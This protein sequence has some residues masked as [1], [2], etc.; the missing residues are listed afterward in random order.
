M[1]RQDPEDNNDHQKRN[2]V[3]YHQAVLDLGPYLRAP[4]VDNIDNKN[5]SIYKKGSLPILRAVVGIIDDQER[6]NDSTSEER[7]RGIASLP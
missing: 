3:H 7:S 1:R 4:D 5:H 2:Y 6:L